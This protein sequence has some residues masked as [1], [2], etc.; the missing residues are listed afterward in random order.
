MDKFGLIGR[1]LKHSYSKKIHAFLGEYSYDLYEIEPEKLSGFVAD[2]TLKGFNVTIPYKKDIITYLDQVDAK[3]KAIGAVNTVVMNNGV[4]TGYNTDFDGMVYMLNRAKISLL[5]RSVLILG[6]GGTS[7]TAKAVCQSLG[8]KSIK[9]LSRSGEINYENYDKLVGDC[10]VVINTT[11]VGTF[12]DNYACK[13]DLSFF[14]NLIGVAD[15]V[16]NPSLTKLLYQAKKL[17]VKYTNG[18]PMLVAQAKYA[19]DLFLGQKTSDSVI[20]DIIST[21]ESQTKNV[22][23][24]GMPG[25][26]KSSI[27]K[28][29]SQ[30]LN[31][32]SIDV[33]SEIVKKDGRSIPTIFSE[34]GE[35]YFRAIEK[36]TLKEIGVLT[37]KIIATGGGVVKDDDNYFALKQNGIIVW[38]DREVE[39]LATDGRPLSKDLSAVKQLYNDRKALYE[40][41]ADIKIENNGSLDYAVSEVKKHL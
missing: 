9:I 39:K 14:P 12:P 34:S 8:A 6:S 23:L 29:L 18:L 30:Q 24:I 13:I 10:E 1:T 16:Y 4:K 21:L 33:D 41:F 28:I 25:C 27:A 22:V 17:G 20:E 15:V 35:E 38:I 2:N 31:R 19:K 36:E 26:G 32:E 11:P 7:G 5:D 3:A 40:K 37:G